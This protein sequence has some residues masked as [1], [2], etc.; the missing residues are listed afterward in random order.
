MAEHKVTLTA[1]ER[2]GFEWRFEC[3]FDPADQSR[4]CWP[5]DDE[6]GL[7]PLPPDDPYAKFCNYQEWWD[8]TE[9]G[10]HSMPKITFPVRSEWK[11]DHM[12][13]HLAA[14]TVEENDD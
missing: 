2:C 13:F 8:N 3:P 5:T 12:Q 14:P 1:D 4:P 10:A 11:H 6:D 7:V 9:N